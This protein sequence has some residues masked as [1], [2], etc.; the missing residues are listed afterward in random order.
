MKLLIKGIIMRDSFFKNTPDIIN[1]AARVVRDILNLINDF[2]NLPILSVFIES[3]SK[4]I[5][6][7][8]KYNYN[9]DCLSIWFVIILNIGIY[10]NQ[11]VSANFVLFI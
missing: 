3:L 6:D 8:Q 2:F 9:G 11:L 5:G 7:K 4:F 1:D 10:F